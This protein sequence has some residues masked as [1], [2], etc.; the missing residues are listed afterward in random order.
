MVCDAAEGLLGVWGEEGEA[1]LDRFLMNK[2]RARVMETPSWLEARLK[3]E[4]LRKT[5]GLRTK[6][7]Q[8]WEPLYA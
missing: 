8:L 5:A 2:V 7:E 1:E 3:G 6:N 4:K